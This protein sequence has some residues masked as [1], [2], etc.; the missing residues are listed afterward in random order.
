MTERVRS[1]LGA[2]RIGQDDSKSGRAIR[3]CGVPFAVRVLGI[4]G[5]LTLLSSC[6]GSYVIR[7]VRG[8][9]VLLSEARPIDEALLEELPDPEVD[10]LREVERILEFAAANGLDV[11]DAYQTFVDVGRDPVVY[12]LTAVPV[13]GVEPR[14]WSFPVVGEFPYKGFFDLDAAVREARHWKARGHDV[15]IGAA[16]AYSTLGYLPD[17]IFSSFFEEDAG[18][19]ADL[20]FHELTHRTVY[21]RGDAAFNETFATFFA[22]RLT[23]QYLGQRFGVGSDELRAYRNQQRDR[24]ALVG[25]ACR[26][27]E[28]IRE[29]FRDAADREARIAAKERELTTF[30]KELSEMQFASERFEGI[31][32][33]RWN[34]PRLL[35]FEIYR[36]DE[37]ALRVAW[38]GSDSPDA[39]LAA[40]EDLGP[41]PDRLEALERALESA[42]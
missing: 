4:V 9:I 38:E 22:R 14:R 15:Y 3:S 40:I 25:A 2:G 33:V 24:K 18:E 5:V 7:Q 36:G 21:L 30:S 12:V 42:P 39:F 20:L 31:A 6:S 26:T 35:I 11:G 23:E 32:N 37:E 13:D 16:A 1:I 41:G 19:L 28:S 34:V 27:L 8:Q 17:P 29:A 10:R